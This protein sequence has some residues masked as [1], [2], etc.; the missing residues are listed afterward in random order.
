MTVVAARAPSSDMSEPR[1]A[2]SSRAVVSRDS[3]HRIH[4]FITIIFFI[5]EAA[6][7]RGNGTVRGRHAMAVFIARI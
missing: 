1:R 6:K 4:S 2:S 5:D 7:S 3:M